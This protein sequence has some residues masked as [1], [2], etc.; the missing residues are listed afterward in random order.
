MFHRRERLDGDV[1]DFD[2]SYYFVSFEAPAGYTVAATGVELGRED[3][4]RRFA[5]G[6]VRDFEV[7]AGRRYRSVERAVGATTVASYYYAEDSRAG[8]RALEFARGAL[9]EW[10]AHFG[11]YPYKRLNVC[12]AP[13]E[14]GMEFSGQVLIDA[15][16]YEDPEDTW[17]LEV[18]I[19]HEVCHQWWALVVGSDSIGRP[20]LDESLVTFCEYAYFLWREDE[21]GALEALRDIRET[22]APRGDDEPDAPAGLPVEEY[23]DSDRYTAIVYG[24][25]ALFFNELFGL[26]GQDRFVKS[27]SGYY[28][29]NAFR[30]VAAEDLLR[31]FRAD[32]PDAE[33]VNALYIRWIVQSHGDEDVAPDPRPL[34]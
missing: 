1:A 21:A 25:G 4:Y 2:S 20:W 5:A 10:Q 16:C 7:Q 24:K 22:Y 6:P 13:L 3:G 12:E 19:A 33:R 28:R 30:T 9:N 11:P 15:S 23:G 8:A 27:L 31:A 29:D 26:M 18:T 34:D 17:D 32:S 14:G